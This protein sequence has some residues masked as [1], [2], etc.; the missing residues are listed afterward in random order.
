MR[1]GLSALGILLLEAAV[2]SI[3]ISAQGLLQIPISCGMRELKQRA[4]MSRENEASP[5]ALRLTSHSNQHGPAYKGQPPSNV[6][7]PSLRANVSIASGR[8]LQMLY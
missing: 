1:G 8:R 6:V 4:D 3:V 2:Q 7:S 5:G